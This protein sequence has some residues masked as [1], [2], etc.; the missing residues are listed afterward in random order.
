MFIIFC[1]V[2]V[3]NVNVSS[4]T[5]ILAKFQE[6]SST[7]EKINDLEASLVL[8][9]SKYDDLVKMYDSLKKEVKDLKIE[10]KS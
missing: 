7:F 8:L 4:T 3:L 5:E 2:Y 6:F 10:N 1:L 9:S